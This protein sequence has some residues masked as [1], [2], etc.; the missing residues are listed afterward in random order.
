VLI[1]DTAKKLYLGEQNT[2]V[3]AISAGRDFVTCT[4]A[5]TYLSALRMKGVELYCSFPNST[6]DF[7]L[8]LE[9]YNGEPKKDAK[10]VR[11]VQK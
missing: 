6:F 1:R 5:I 8:S 7:P 2:W 4:A 10:P 3:K 11:R 9:A